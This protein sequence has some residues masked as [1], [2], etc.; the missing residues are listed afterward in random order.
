MQQRRTNTET[1]I[2]K[3]GKNE[4]TNITNLSENKLR[5]KTLKMIVRGAPSIR[6]GRGAGSGTFASDA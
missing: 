4:E 2:Q 1:V 5:T 3:G 6:K